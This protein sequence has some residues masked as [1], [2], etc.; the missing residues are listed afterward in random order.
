LRYR[1]GGIGEQPGYQHPETNVI[2]MIQAH[3]ISGEKVL[4]CINPFISVSGYLFYKKGKTD[5][6]PYLWGDLFVSNEKL[7]MAEMNKKIFRKVMMIDDDPI[8][9]F[10]SERILQVN[11]FATE[12][13]KFLKAEDALDYL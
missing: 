1:V 13:T 8:E 6:L 12:I 10:I 7:L 2:I 5:I 11:H 4:V 9:H 3:N